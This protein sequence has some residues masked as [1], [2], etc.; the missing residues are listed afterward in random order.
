MEELEQLIQK[1][2][3]SR[4]DITEI[5]IRDFGISNDLGDLIAMDAVAQAVGPDR[6]KE[7]KD[8]ERK[9]IRKVFITRTAKKVGLVLGVMLG[10]VLVGYVSLLAYRFSNKPDYPRTYESIPEVTRFEFRERAWMEDYRLGI[11]D[12]NFACVK[13]FTSKKYSDGD[14]LA[15]T[16]V[17]P[18]KLPSLNKAMD[19]AV[20]NN[21]DGVIWNEANGNG[22]LWTVEHNNY[23]FIITA[24]EDPNYK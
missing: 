4:Q 8:K 10:I 19:D 3:K 16:C 17:N 22:E 7:L 18:A 9:Q 11:S 6:I 13:N 15:K 14:G 21:T 1:E 2:I 12:T 24:T 20:F 5:L 23:R